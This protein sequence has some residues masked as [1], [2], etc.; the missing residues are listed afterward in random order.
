MDF[1]DFVFTPAT[2]VD[3]LVGAWALGLILGGI[4]AVLASVV[5]RW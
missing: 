3:V 4:G 1:L 2:V 5:R